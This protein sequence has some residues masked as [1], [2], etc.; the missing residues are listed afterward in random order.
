MAASRAVRTGFNQAVSKISDANAEKL[1]AE[2][3]EVSEHLTV[4][5][6]HAV[7]QKKVYSRK[8]LAEVCGLGTGPGFWDGIAVTVITHSSQ[9]LANGLTPTNNWKKSTRSPQTRRNGEVRNTQDT[10][11]RSTNA[12]WSAA[13]GCRMKRFD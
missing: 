7:W 3:F 9:G 10:K 5:P 6:S 1:H 13:C 2:Y 12:H 8:Q 11:R 4:R